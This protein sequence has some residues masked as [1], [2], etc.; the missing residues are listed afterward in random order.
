MEDIKRTVRGFVLE[1][2]LMGGREQLGDEQSF[3]AHHI[4]DST[5]FIELVTFLEGEYGIQVRD[6]EMI[7]E[8]LDSV[9]N[10]EQFIR[11]K[12]RIAA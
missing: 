8:N 7:P 2:F 1:N 9:S 3:L 11:A 10:I 12:K 4:V 5:G 6:E